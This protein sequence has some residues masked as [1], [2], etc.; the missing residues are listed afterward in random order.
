MFRLVHELTQGHTDSINTLAFSPCGVYLA[1]GGDDK[2]LI[3][4]RVSDG[5]LLYQLV[6]ESA[7]TAVIWHPTAKGVIFCACE[8]GAFCCLKDLR[9][10]C[11]LRQQSAQANILQTRVMDL[12]QHFLRSTYTLAWRVKYTASTMTATVTA[13]PLVLRTWF[14]LQRR[15]HKVCFTPPFYSTANEALNDQAN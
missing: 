2:Q 7:V 4:W 6:L 15:L 5:T 1:S 9:K 12:R 11:H 13:L 8:N 14:R 3:I 10:V